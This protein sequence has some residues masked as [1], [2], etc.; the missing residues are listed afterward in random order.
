MVAGGGGSGEGGCW[1]RGGCSY[2][3]VYSF[4]RTAVINGHK[5]LG[6]KQHKFIHLPF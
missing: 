4:P 5:F 2:K 6:L 3:S 1:S